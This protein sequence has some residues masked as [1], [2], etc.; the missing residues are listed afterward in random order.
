M[1]NSTG[2]KT[3]SEQWRLNQAVS[4][5]TASRTASASEALPSASS[6]NEILSSAVAVASHT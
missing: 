2:Q 1:V 6:A 3:L 5:A 4:V